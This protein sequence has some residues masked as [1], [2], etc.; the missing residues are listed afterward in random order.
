MGEG[1]QGSQ[2]G[3][4]ALQEGTAQGTGAAVPSTQGQGQENLPAEL[5]SRIVSNQTEI[6]I[7]TSRHFSN[8]IAFGK[9]PGSCTRS[10]ANPL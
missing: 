7:K 5:Q 10:K 1:A 3:L 9:R 8:A 6:S 2:A 4:G